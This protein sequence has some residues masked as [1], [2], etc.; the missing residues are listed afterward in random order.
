MTACP[1]WCYALFAGRTRR[2]LELVLS[3]PAMGVVSLPVK[4]Q[5]VVRAL[6]ADT[7]SFDENTLSAIVRV[8]PHGRRANARPTEESIGS[9]N[10][11]IRIR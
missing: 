7:L 6:T 2:R 4:M 10:C 5:S 3:P 11:R 8:G 1:A 9:G